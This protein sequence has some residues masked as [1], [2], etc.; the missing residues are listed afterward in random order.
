[1]NHTESRAINQVLT[2][3]PT[4]DGAGV[5]L[6]RAFGSPSLTELLDPFLLLD[7]LRST[8]PTDYSAGFPWHPHRG[9]ETVT[10]VVK[11]RFEHQDS[12]G[13]GGV[14]K[15][16]EVQWMTAGGG[17]FHAEMPKETVDKAMWGYQ[18]WVNLPAR[19][20]MTQPKYR[21]MSDTSIPEV[22]LENGAKVKLIAGRIGETMG[23]AQD[24]AVDVEYMDVSIPKGAQFEH[25]V[26]EGYTAFA[27]VID[28]DAKFSH[29][30]RN[31]TG[32]GSVV[33]Y[34]RTKPKVS[35]KTE[36]SSVRFL[37]GIGKPLKEPVA[38]HGPVVMSTWD[39]I[40]RAFTDLHDG[41]FLKGGTPSYSDQ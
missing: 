3:R 37:L 9:I 36:D 31:P 41:T 12:T 25:P 8:N 40:N 29:N 39:E 10:Y 28:G 38:W 22:E 17:I 1:M 13:G 11:G 5:R 24:L 6:T 23:P 33:L 4:T 16:G 18:L 14:I 34:E 30:T 15:T 32:P 7:E 27:Y 2:G 20:K 19:H 26:K 35:V 21:N